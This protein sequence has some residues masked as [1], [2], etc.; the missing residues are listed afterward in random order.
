MV[1]KHVTTHRPRLAL[2]I[3]ASLGISSAIAQTPPDTV[4]VPKSLNLGTTSFFDG[5][6]N[7]DGGWTWMQ[8]GRYE[9]IDRSNDAQGRSSPYVKGTDIQV[10]VTQTQICYASPWHPFGGD[11]VGFSALLPFASVNAHFAADSPVKLADNGAGMGDL[12]WG[13]SYQ[14]RLIRQGGRPILSWRLQFLFVSPTG[15]F[16]PNHDIDQ[17]EGFWAINP[18]IA[19]TYLP[20]PK[21]EFSTRLNYQ[22]NMQSANLPNPPRIPGLVYRNAQA[23][24][25]VYGNLDASYQISEKLHLGINGYFLDQLAPDKTNG[26]IVPHSRASEIYAGPGARFVFSKAN[27]LN[28][29]LYLPI[30][31][32]NDTS[33]PQINFQFMHRF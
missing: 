31:S 2:L 16:N 11:A 10:F 4:R 25:M 9:D 23:G 30:Q 17:S 22:Y 21:W 15:R 7:T 3:F 18:Y 33:G 14:S 19:I 20:L 12:V 26:A 27:A 13:P 28:L 32:R 1:R 8:Y 6:G 24:D 5:L 29:N